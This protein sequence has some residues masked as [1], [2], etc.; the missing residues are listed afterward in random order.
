M[1]SDDPLLE[2]HEELWMVQ[3]QLGRL[4]TERML[5]LLSPA[6]ED[7]YRV[8]AARELELIADLADAI[9]LAVQID[10]TDSTT[11]SAQE[12]SDSAAVRNRTGELG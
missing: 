8:L 1:T 11:L 5:H 10:I 12:G 9:D 7:S 3:R 2:L 4:S 6:E